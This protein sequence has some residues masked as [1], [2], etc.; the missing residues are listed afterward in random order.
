MCILCWKALVAGFLWY[1][2][3]WVMSSRQGQKNTKFPWNAVKGYLKKK[4]K[5]K[6]NEGISSYFN[7]DTELMRVKTSVTTEVTAGQSDKG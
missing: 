7:Y 1:V 5:R 2:L 6:K 3:L 4:K